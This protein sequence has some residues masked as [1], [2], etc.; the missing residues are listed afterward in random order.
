LFFL[1]PCFSTAYHLLRAPTKLIP[2]FDLAKTAGL[3]RKPYFYI[4][5]TRSAHAFTV[6]SDTLEYAFFRERSV[7]LLKEG[8]DSFFDVRAAQALL[9]TALERKV[10]SFEFSHSLTAARE[11]ARSGVKGISVQAPVFLDGTP[12]AIQNGATVAGALRVATLN[13][14]GQL[15]TFAQVLADSN[16]AIFDFQVQRAIQSPTDE[17]YRA[18]ASGRVDDNDGGSSGSSRASS[19]ALSSG[20]AAGLGIAATLCLCLVLLLTYRAFERRKHHDPQQTSFYPPH[21][22]GED[23]KMLP[24]TSR[25]FEVP[26]E[27]PTGSLQLGDVLA[28]SSTSTVLRGY[29]RRGSR[30]PALPVAVKIVDVR[31]STNRRSQVLQEMLMLAQFRRHRNIVHLEGV[32]TVRPHQLL[33][34]TELCHRATL[35][36]YLRCRDGRRSV[37]WAVKFR[38]AADVADGLAVIHGSNIVHM[39]VSASNVLVTAEG[40]CKVADLGKHLG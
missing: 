22:F 24:L 21:D 9:Y 31:E 2:F 3:C 36:E 20:A 4:L 10:N 11:A 33:I 34:V 15:V 17:E 19:R 25:P 32:I 40:V 1:I 18:V 12:I 37:S 38:L 35:S 16:L 29:L 28:E 26:F 23:L 13:R 27:L 30:A 5:P 6:L 14:A 7:L 8:Y 39:N